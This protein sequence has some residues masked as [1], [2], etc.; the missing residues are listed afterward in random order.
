[1][2]CK[3][4]VLTSQVVSLRSVLL[5]DRYAE[6][7][8]AICERALEGTSPSVKYFGIL[9]PDHKNMSAESCPAWSMSPGMGLLGRLR[10]SV[11]AKPRQHLRNRC[12]C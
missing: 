7:G 6:F 2:T 4:A 3:D 5:T 9:R 1:M 10:S 12:L 11:R 8:L